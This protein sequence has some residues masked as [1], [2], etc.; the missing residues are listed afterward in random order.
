MLQV[1][2]CTNSFTT[3][4]NK[5]DATKPWTPKK[6]DKNHCVQTS[7]T[8]GRKLWTLPKM[9]NIHNLSIAKYTVHTLTY[10]QDTVRK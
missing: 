7:R 2:Q 1:K 4:K 8:P 6:G 3:G 10:L 5:Y 9:I